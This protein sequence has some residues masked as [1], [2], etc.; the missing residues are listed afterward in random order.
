[1]LFRSG[2]LLDYIEAVP[3]LEG[4]AE[5]ARGK[6]AVNTRHGPVLEALLSRIP[7]EIATGAFCFDA[8]SRRD[9]VA[10]WLQ[11]NCEQPLSW[12]TGGGIGG[13]CEL[14]K[15]TNDRK[16]STGE[17]IEWDYFREEVVRRISNQLTLDPTYTI[18]AWGQAVVPPADPA[19][20]LT[21]LAET[22]MMAIVQPERDP[23]TGLPER[24]RLITM[25]ILD[26]RGQ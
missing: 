15:L 25:R 7:S 2:R 26:D 12:V 1:M 24:L 13:I 19:A 4:A 16:G 8:A 11:R 21:V 14:P 6:I 10:Q 17:T 18:L 20:P 9:A 23:E 3:P 22:R 5:L